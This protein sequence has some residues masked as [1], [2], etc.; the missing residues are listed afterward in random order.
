MWY[1]KL[2][3]NEKDAIEAALQA[4]TNQS[5]SAAIDQT[6]WLLLKLHPTQQQWLDLFMATTEPYLNWGPGQKYWRFFGQLPINDFRPQWNECT[7]APV[8]L[9]HWS[10][11][12]FFAN[13]R[14]PGARCFECGAGAVNVWH[15]RNPRHPDVFCAQCWVKFLLR[16]DDDVD[17]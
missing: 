15:S 5:V 6:T 17:T 7:I 1:F 14:S 13:Q 2:F 11:N 10:T 3:Q 8:G 9:E 12:Y 16:T 4:K